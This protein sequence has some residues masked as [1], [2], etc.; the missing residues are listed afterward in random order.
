MAL[1]IQ[2]LKS[3]ASYCNK[4][5]PKTNFWAAVNDVFPSLIERRGKCQPFHP[6]RQ[7]PQR[8]YKSSQGLEF[9]ILLA[10]QSHWWTRRGQVLGK[11]AK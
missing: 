9:S 1:V 11:G 6:R 4:K 7:I 3:S 8:W 10:P 5:H 2:A